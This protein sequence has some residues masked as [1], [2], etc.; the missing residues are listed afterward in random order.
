MLLL[1]ALPA[2]A[3]DNGWY[4]NEDSALNAYK[5]D[6][7]PRGKDGKLMYSTYYYYMIMDGSKRLA[8]VDKDSNLVVLDS[9]N[10]I[11]QLILNWKQMA[12]SLAWYK[13]RI[14]KMSDTIDDMD[15]TILRLI[16]YKSAT[17]AVLEEISATGEIKDMKK[18]TEAYQ[19]YLKYK[20]QLI[21]K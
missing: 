2:I 8:Y 3:Q 4:L 13:E 14:D 7:L 10:T 15:K 6:T 20:K 11:R 9:L 17:S 12:E 21:I 5:L 16:Y 1:T 18:F 19:D